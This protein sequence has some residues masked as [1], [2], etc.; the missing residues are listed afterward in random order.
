MV[1]LTSFE[2]MKYADSRRY[3]DSVFS[4]FTSV[5]T[6]ASTGAC[7]GYTTTKPFWK[8]DSYQDRPSTSPFA[9]SGS[10]D[11]PSSSS[12]SSSNKRRKKKSKFIPRKAAVQLTEK[13][14]TLF[15]R[16]LESNPSKDGILLNYQQSSTGEPRMV[17]SFS[18][19]TKDQLV[20]EDE[21]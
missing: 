14:R 13:A 15:K 8:D 12:S 16:L 9:R 17:F 19:V 21:G 10:G 20:E 1:R 5:D 18:F 4:I 3:S 11:K 2:M 7:R 6:I